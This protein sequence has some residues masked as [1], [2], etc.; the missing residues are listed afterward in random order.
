MQD[1]GRVE[2]PLCLLWL[3]E[4]MITVMAESNHKLEMGM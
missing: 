3:T 1:Y 4:G 2:L